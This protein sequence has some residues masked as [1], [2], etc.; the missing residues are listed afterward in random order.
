MSSFAVRFSSVV[1]VATCLAL[2][3]CGSDSASAPVVTPVTAQVTVDASTSY[4]YLRL[5][6]TSQVVSPADP[7][8]SAAWDLG[9][10]ATNVV[11]NGGAVGPG[12]VTAYCVCQNATLPNAA[13]SGLTAASEL[14]A[15]EGVVAAQIPA[16][17]SFSSDQLTPAIAGWFSGTGASATAV[18]A[19]AWL[20]RKGTTTVTLGKFR[21]T[22]IASASAANAGQVTFEY[23]LQ[24]TVGGAFGASQTAA[25]DLRGGPVY[26]DLTAGAAT[27]ATGTWDLR[28]TGFEIRANGGV[29]GT[30]SVSALVD[31]GMPY[32]SIT[33]TYA[34]T[35]PSTVFKKDAYSGVFVSQPWYKYNITGT[36]NQIWPTFNVY[37]VKRGTDIYKVQL[38]SYYGVTGTSRQISVRYARLR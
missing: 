6:T 26:Y 24:S 31:N 4:G 3:A 11:V 2:S 16:D 22:A 28:I 9:L 29:S 10:F 20:L 14:P 25:V 12:G 23:A 34:A 33:A 13:L 19:R 32:A 36:D 21:V 8:T 5:G 15:F 38:T 7:S 30:G 1:L 27:T 37:L 35:A 17:A 18:P